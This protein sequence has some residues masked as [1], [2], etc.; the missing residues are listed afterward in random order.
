MYSVGDSSSDSI[1]ATTVVT[2]TIV[3]E[4]ETTVEEMTTVTQDIDS[5]GK[6]DEPEPVEEEGPVTIDVAPN[7]TSYGNI[8]NGGFIASDGE[9]SYYRAS[10]GYLYRDD[11]KKLLQHQIWYINVYDGY[12]YF[13]DET[14]CCL[15]RMRTDGSDYKLLYNDSVHEVNVYEDKVYFATA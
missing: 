11:G 6:L 5:V 1:E 8:C 15:A 10:D 9:Y 4:T 2:T 14:D 3:K 13:S 7:G 12:L